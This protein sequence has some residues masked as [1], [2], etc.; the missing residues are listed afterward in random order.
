[1]SDSPIIGIT[2]PFPEAPVDGTPYNRQDAGWVREP[3]Y[4]EEAPN[5]GNIYGRQNLAWA[6]I[7]GVSIVN[8]TSDATSDALP[9]IHEAWNDY[10]DRIPVVR[11]SNEIIFFNWPST[12]SDNYQYTGNQLVAPWTSTVNDWVSVGGGTVSWG[13]I[14]GDINTQTDLSNALGAKG[15][16][17]IDYTFLA[18]TTATDP[19]NGG[20]KLNNADPALATE[21]YVSANSGAG[22]T[23]T[24]FWNGYQKGDLLKMLEVGGNFSFTSYEITASPVNNTSWYT[25]G[26]AAL[27]NIGGAL[28]AGD[29]TQIYWSSDPRSTVREGGT[30]GQILSKSDGN[31]YNQVWIDLPVS[32]GSTEEVIT[33]VAHGFTVG[34]AIRHNGTVFALAMA[35]SAATTALGLVVAVGGADEFT[36]AIS[37]VYNIGNH[38]LISGQ[39]YYLSDTVPG[40]LQDSVPASQLEQ[41]ILHVRDANTVTIVPYRPSDL[42][43]S[44]VIPVGEAPEDGTPY[45]RQDGGWVPAGAGTVLLQASML[46]M[47]QEMTL[48]REE[49]EALKA[50]GG[51]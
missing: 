47:W 45:E 37:G 3:Q 49:L 14:T 1:M 26:I 10:G 16:V 19:L 7:L 28:A 17:G 42:S 40:A 21:M 44:G 35:D 46:K 5:D 11:G 51:E 36:Y 32:G 48:L 34:Q 22:N 9:T 38:G 18:D 12:S 6:E 25:V 4:T 29:H 13:S 2:E 27:E 43:D 15:A 24:R 39:W 23:L 20:I 50:A 31:D 8:Y 33:Q 41:V 30:A